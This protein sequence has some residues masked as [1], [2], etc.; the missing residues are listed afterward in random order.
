MW[1][2]VAGRRHREGPRFQPGD[3]EAEKIRREI[4]RSGRGRNAAWRSASIPLVLQDA[5]SALSLGYV[6]PVL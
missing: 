6:Y 5:Y 2:R 4:K 3:V 1:L